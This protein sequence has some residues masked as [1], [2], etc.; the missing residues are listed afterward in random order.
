[1][2]RQFREVSCLSLKTHMLVAEL[3]TIIKTWKQLKFLSMDEWIKC[4]C[5]CCSATQSDSLRPHGLQHTR[6]HCPSLSPGVCSNSCPLSRWCHPNISSS[7]I[8]FSSCPQSFPAWPSYPMSWLFILGGQSIGAS[9]SASVPPMNIQGWI[10]L[11]LIGLISFLSK[12]LKNLLQHHTL[13]GSILCHSAF[14]MAQ[15]S[16]PYMSTGKTI[17]LTLWAFVGKVISLQ[18]NI[19]YS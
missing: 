1:M 18:Q 7:V 12:G 4:S 19:I 6:L 15:L 2:N 3:P 11:E 5:C 16:H 9:A 14:F 13:K 17:A 10:S 8:S